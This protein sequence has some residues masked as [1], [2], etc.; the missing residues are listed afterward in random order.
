MDKCPNSSVRTYT[1][2][3]STLARYAQLSP[4]VPVLGAIADAVCPYAGGSLAGR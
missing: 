4:I 1:H 2:G 3:P